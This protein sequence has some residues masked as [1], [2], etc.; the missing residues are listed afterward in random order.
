MI[1]NI[2]IGSVIYTATDVCIMDIGLVTSIEPLKVRSRS[3]K[4]DEDGG[5]YYGG[6]DACNWINSNII[7]S[8]HDWDELTYE[9]TTEQICDILGLNYQYS[10]EKFIEWYC[11]EYEDQLHV[12][13][14]FKVI[15][16]NIKDAAYKFFTELKYEDEIIKKAINAQDNIEDI[17]K[18]LSRLGSYRIINIFTIKDWHYCSIEKE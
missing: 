11:F 7:M 2:N 1:K 8:E 15:S 17:I 5:I 9:K 6:P 18:L 10:K 3:T 14:L 12:F 16:N 4:Y 13:K